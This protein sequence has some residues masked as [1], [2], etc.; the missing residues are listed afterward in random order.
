MG[1]L[2]VLLNSELPSRAVAVYLVLNEYADK[3]GYCFPSLKTIAQA[4]APS[5]GLYRT[6]LKPDLYKGNSATV[7]MG[8]FPRV[9]IICCSGE[10][11]VGSEMKVKN[12]T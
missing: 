12:Y 6:L 11:R 1:R 10:H 3:N 9:C 5:K 7:K 4:K 2:S 8:R